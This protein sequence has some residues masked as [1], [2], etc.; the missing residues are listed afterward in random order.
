MDISVIGSIKK[1]ILSWLCIFISVC[2]VSYPHISIGLLTFIMLLFYSY[3]IHY[4][5][6]NVRNVFTIIHHYHHENNDFFAHISQ[7]LLE[8][9]FPIVL[10]PVYLLYNTIYFNPWVIGLY[11]FFYSTV[12]NVNYSILK[13]NNVHSRHHKNIFTNIGPDICD[14]IFKTKNSEDTTCENTIHY[15]P[16]VIIGTIIV[17]SLKYCCQNETVKTILIDILIFFLTFSL[18]FLFISALY[19]N[20]FY[21]KKDLEDCAMK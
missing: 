2:I 9:T 21:E 17:L 15:I 18:I 5:A 20:N 3:Y 10:I 7:I 13:V 19:L 16:N 11:G 4:I 12:H 1:N 14:V 6:H 8:I